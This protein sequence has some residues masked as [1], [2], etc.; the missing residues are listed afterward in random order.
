MTKIFK[1]KEQNMSLRNYFL[2]IK[3]LKMMTNH[4]AWLKFSDTRLIIL[5]RLETATP[6]RALLVTLIPSFY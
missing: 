1:K 4:D 6:R 5:P 2:K 3:K